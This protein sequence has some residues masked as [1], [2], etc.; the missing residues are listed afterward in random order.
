[1]K[2]IITLFILSYALP[3]V[4]QTNYTDDLGKKQ[5]KWVKKYDGGKIRYTGTFRDDIPIGTFTYFF[6][7]DGGIQAKRKE[8]RSRARNE[9]KAH[10]VYNFF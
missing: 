1:M 4:A 2:Y 6:E 10:K 5:G 9:F 7:R 8:Q 3:V